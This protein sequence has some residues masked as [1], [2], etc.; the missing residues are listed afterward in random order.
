[1]LRSLAKT[2]LRLGRPASRAAEAQGTHAG[3]TSLAPSGG[4]N[5]SRRRQNGAGESAW[6]RAPEGT[7]YSRP[8]RGW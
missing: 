4:A 3:A 8:F 6:W 5:Y 1:M 7:F 2:H